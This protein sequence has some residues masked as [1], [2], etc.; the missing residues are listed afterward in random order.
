MSR[1]TCMPSV[2]RPDMEG[3]RQV[4]HGPQPEGFLSIRLTCSFS[5]ALMSYGDPE[6]PTL[7][8]HGRG[9]FAACYAT[10]PATPRK[11]TSP[12]ERRF[13]TTSPYFKP[14]RSCDE[15]DQPTA[16]KSPS[17][18]SKLASPRS[19]RT[20]DADGMV[21]LEDGD[22]PKPKISVHIDEATYLQYGVD[23]ILLK[24][25]LHAFNLRKFTN[26]YA[27]LWCVKP[28]LI[29]GTDDGQASATAIL[30]HL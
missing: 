24:D 4:S 22:T 6:C 17:L 15:E 9:S 12:T 3:E 11:D 20:A 30:R 19:S 21:Q 13:P 28:T 23:P 18:L 14:A 29:Q 2:P 10:P 27:T 5:I 16:A 25:P 26:M 7:T 1:L 8:A